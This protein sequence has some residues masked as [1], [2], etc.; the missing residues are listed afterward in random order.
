MRIAIIGSGISGLVAARRLSQD[1]EVHVL[2]AN[3][4]VGGHTHTVDVE[5]AGER[6]AVDTGVIVFNDRTYPNFVRLLSELGVGS[7]ATTMSFSVRC[8]RTGLEYRGA[9]PGGL[10]AQRSNLLNLRFYRLLADWLRFNRRGAEFLRG[11][12]RLTVGQFLARE[13][14][15]REFVEQYFLPMGSAVWSCP[16][17]RFQEFPIRFIL[18]F[19]RNHGLLS[20]RGRPQWRVVAGG[21]RSYIPPLIRPF[22][23]RIR[24]ATPVL[25][26]E[27]DDERARLHLPGGEIQ[28][29]DH[30]VFACH[31]DQA[32]RIL[33]D[34]ATPLEREVLSAFPY[35]PNEVVLHTDTSLL[36]RTRRAWAAWNYLVPR[37]DPGKSTVT[38]NMNLLQRLAARATFCVT[39]NGSDRIDPSRVLQRFN[40]HHPVFTMRRA[41]AQRRHRDLLTAHRTSFCGAYWGNGF[42]EDGVNSALAVCQAISG[43]EQTW[44]PASMRVGSGIAATDELLTTSATGCT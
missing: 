41:E 2:E 40:Y 6:Q 29:F 11:N 9:D 38:Y 34:A 14:F 30:V 27:R 17:D 42:H 35:E 5:A 31:S 22:R 28:D 24:L 1:H 23:S 8:E 19:F 25:R 37:E 21:S 4:Y 3:C 39:L 15:S 18:E 16:R 7:Q 36:P 12:E 26:V 33:G 13:R 20:L 43:K 10:F 32:L 44:N